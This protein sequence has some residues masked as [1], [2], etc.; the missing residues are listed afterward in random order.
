MS[1]ISQIIKENGESPTSW[2]SAGREIADTVRRF[3]KGFICVICVIC[4]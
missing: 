3:Y 2:P 4:G 1:Q